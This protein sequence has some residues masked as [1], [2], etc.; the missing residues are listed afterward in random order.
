M[1]PDPLM[2]AIRASAAET[3]ADTE[4]LDRCAEKLQVDPGAL[5]EAAIQS[6]TPLSILAE[7]THSLGPCA[8]RLTMCGVDE[9]RLVTMVRV[10][11]LRAREA[12]RP[13]G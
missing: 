11:C 3:Y 13:T 8:I 10:A 4:R 6:G 5:R 1:S 12:M 2:D 7:A 9:E